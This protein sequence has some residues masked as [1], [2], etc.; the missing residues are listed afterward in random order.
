MAVGNSPP[1]EE[2]P[3]EQAADGPE[4]QRGPT[5]V[6]PGAQR[7]ITGGGGGPQCGLAGGACS[8]SPARPE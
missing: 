4:A 3:D 5:G 7:G 6:S 1:P 2:S 8:Q